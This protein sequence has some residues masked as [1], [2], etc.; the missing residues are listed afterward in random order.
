MVQKRSLDGGNSWTPLQVVWGDGVNYVGNACPVADR[1]TGVVWLLLSRN[2]GQDPEDGITDGTTGD[3]RTVWVTCSADEGAT[4]S[5]PREITQTVKR[6]EWTWYATGPGVGIQLR[7]GRLLIPC[8][9]AVKVSGEGTRNARGSSAIPKVYRSHVIYSDDHG[10]SWQLGGIAGDHVNECQVAELADGSLLLNMRNHYDR[11]RRALATS[12]DGGL[13]WSLMAFDEALVDSCCQAGLLR[14]RDP[15]SGAP[16]PLLF[17]NPAHATERVAM[18]VRA[19]CDE[20]ASWPVRRLLWAGPSGY[21]CLAVMPD[22]DV[23][24]LYERGDGDAHDEWK[25]G[26]LPPWGMKIAFSRFPLSWL[27]AGA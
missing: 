13:T 21:S 2:R 19:S 10:Q 7:S 4:W 9:H 20:G 1:D 24:C 12:R 26:F 6:P 15:R 18:T 5:A 16:G 23:A 11:H 17:S 22:G 8:D 27:T 3:T 25:S 14:Y